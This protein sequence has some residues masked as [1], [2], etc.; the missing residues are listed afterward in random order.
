MGDRETYGGGELTIKEL[1]ATLEFRVVA[2]IFCLHICVTL[3]NG[4]QRKEMVS[5][6]Q[7]GPPKAR[8]RVYTYPP[9]LSHCSSWEQTPVPLETH[10]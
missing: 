7:P 8:V 6:R 3:S 4:L 1:K 10:T 5:D 2:L 9:Q